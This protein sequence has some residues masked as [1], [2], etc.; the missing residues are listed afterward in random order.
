MD[1]RNYHQFPTR[2]RRRYVPAAMLAM[3]P[4]GTAPVLVLVDGT[5]IDES[6]S[7]TQAPYGRCRATSA[8]DS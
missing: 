1:F 3:S 6:I 2:I 4:K 7:G 5:V 8:A